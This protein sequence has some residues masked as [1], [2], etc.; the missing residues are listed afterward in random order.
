MAMTGRRQI[1]ALVIAV[2]GGYL[3]NV[4][5]DPARD[6]TSA[7]LAL[8]AGTALGLGTLIW[9]SRE[10]RPGYYVPAPDELAYRPWKP[11]HFLSCAKQAAPL[12]VGIRLFLFLEWFEAFSHKWADPAWHSGAALNGFWQRAI[13][14]GPTG[15]TPTTFVEYRAF[16]QWLIDT[17]AASWLTYVIMGGEL[18]IALGLFFGCLTGWAAFFGFLM[19][20]SFLLAGTTSTNP[21]LVILEL[22]CMFGYSVAGYWGLD[23]WLLPAIGTPWG[24]HVP[25]EGE[26]DHE[27]TP[28]HHESAA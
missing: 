23:R 27:P 20:M 12:Y 3:L 17:N 11:V 4:S 21:L 22:A 9:L 13:T 24:R 14:P 8:V 26:M 6:L 19:N 28:S 18:A 1:I 10:Y 16:L 5:A 25:P 15:A 7:M 2:V